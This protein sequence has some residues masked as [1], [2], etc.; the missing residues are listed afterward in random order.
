MPQGLQ[1][2]DAQGRLVCDISD[3]LGRVIDIV[4]TGLSDGSISVPGFSWGTPWASVQPYD[5]NVFFTPTVTIQGTTLSWS[6]P[7]Q[8]R[9]A[10]LLIY[11]VM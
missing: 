1:A 11:G 5:S 7:Q 2:W 10:C 9:G 6:F 3:R 4:D 8:S